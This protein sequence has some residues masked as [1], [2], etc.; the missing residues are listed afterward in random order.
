[1][2]TPSLELF[3]IVVRHPTTCFANLILAAECLTLARWL[4]DQDTVRAEL[5][6]RF[7]LFM[8]V[9]TLAGA[10]K[11]GIPHYLEGSP[12]AAVLLVSGFATGLSTFFAG[13]ATIE[14]RAGSASGVR[15]VEVLVSLQL[16]AFTLVFASELAFGLVALNTALGLTPVMAAELRA[17]LRGDRPGR[18]VFGGLA[19]SMLTGVVYGLE[20]SISAWFN[21]IDAAHMLMMASLVLIYHGAKPPGR[22]SGSA[23]LPRAWLSESHIHP[24]RAAKGDNL[25]PLEVVR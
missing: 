8:A 10:A 18:L 4:R 16:V 14:S 15:A 2:P 12:L 23:R 13:L 21:H 9:A 20:L 22:A 17:G 3:G 6:S 5:W 7:L 1:M 19:L 11:H 25:Q 24:R